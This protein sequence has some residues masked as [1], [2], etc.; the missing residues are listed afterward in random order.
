MRF[1]VISDVKIMDIKDISYMLL[2]HL[3][4]QDSHS[5]PSAHCGCP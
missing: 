5:M 2:K 4:Q 3:L 1:S